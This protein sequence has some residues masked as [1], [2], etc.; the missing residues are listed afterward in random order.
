MLCRCIVHWDFPMPLLYQ[1]PLK[2]FGRELQS[3]NR[4][5]VHW[6]RQVCPPAAFLRARRDIIERSA[7]LDLRFHFSSISNF[8][9]SMS[10]NWCIHPWNLGRYARSKGSLWMLLCALPGLWMKYIRL[11]Y[12]GWRDCQ[13]HS[14][15]L[16]WVLVESEI[17]CLVD[18]RCR[19]TVL[20]LFRRRWFLSI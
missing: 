16:A 14:Q 11:A 15:R 13:R 19:N 6:W 17:L 9:C 8:M 5:S 4:K 1:G 20:V 3:V 2:S 10:I 18:S 12:S 7:V